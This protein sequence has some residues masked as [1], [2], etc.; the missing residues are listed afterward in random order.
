MPYNPLHVAHPDYSAWMD[1]L[2]SLKGVVNEKAMQSTGIRRV[3]PT[4]DFCQRRNDVY[5]FIISLYTFSF[6]RPSHTRMFRPQRVSTAVLGLRG[7]V[8]V[9]RSEIGSMGL[10]TNGLAGARARSVRWNSSARPPLPP[11]RPN[12]KETPTPATGTADD[13]VEGEPKHTLVLERIGGRL[14]H[15]YTADS[16]GKVTKAWSTPTKWY[17]IPIALGALVLLAVQFRK[18]QGDA[19]EVES[20]REGAVVRSSKIDGPWQVSRLLTVTEP[21]HLGS[22]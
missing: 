1:A 5:R 7:A 19:I 3:D 9:H 4:F 14:T 8:S 21:F 18:S 22:H 13:T 10:R 20:Q 12:L 11:S 16:L 15:W 17:P 6:P 2:V